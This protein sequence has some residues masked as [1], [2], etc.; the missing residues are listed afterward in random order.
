MKLGN[1]INLILILF[2][3]PLNFLIAEDKITTAPLINV[4]Q[5]A[6]SFEVPEEEYKNISSDKNLKKKKK[7]HFFKIGSSNF[8]RSR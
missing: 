5:I 2:F 7:N 6:P 8:N 4:E 3:F 1:K